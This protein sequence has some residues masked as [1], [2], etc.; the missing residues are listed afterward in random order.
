MELAL[1]WSEWKTVWMLVMFDLPVVTKEQRH[2]YAKFRKQLIEIGFT[3][4]QYSVYARYLGTDERAKHYIRAVESILPPEGQ[5]R[6]LSV[7]GK[8][9]ENQ[10]V[11]E[12]TRRKPPE[13]EPL[14]LELF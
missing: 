8:Q 2:E 7:T 12:K 3:K 6:I 13:N 11:F 14:Q 5:V 1:R 10:V 9:F 4:L